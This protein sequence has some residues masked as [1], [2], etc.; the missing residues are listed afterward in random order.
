MYFSVKLY[1]IYYGGQKKNVKKNQQKNQCVFKFIL[2]FRVSADL[3]W[4]ICTLVSLCISPTRTVLLNV[5]RV[6]VCV[7]ACNSA[8]QPPPSLPVRLSSR[9][10]PSYA[11]VTIKTWLCTRISAGRGVSIP[12]SRLLPECFHL[13]FPSQTLVPFFSSDFKF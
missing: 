5:D 7:R 12:P 3:E 1:L 6:S 13:C 2:D 11:C 10:I 8:G 9:L 4:W